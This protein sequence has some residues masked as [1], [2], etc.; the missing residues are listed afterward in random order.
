M[1]SYVA[2]LKIIINKFSDCGEKQF[3]MASLPMPRCYHTSAPVANRVI[4]CNGESQDYSV[5]NRLRLASTVEEFYPHSEQW[6]ARQCTGEAP[7][8]GVRRSASASS[9]GFLFTYGGRD[10]DDKFLGS[11]HQLSAKTYE[12]NELSPQNAQGDVPM[13]KWGAAMVACDDVLAL[14]GGYG[15]PHGPT[16]R[17]SSF[18]KNTGRSDGRGWTNEFHIY[19][20]KEG[21]DTCTIVTK[22]WLGFLSFVHVQVH[23]CTL[24][25]LNYSTI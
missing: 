2:L 3:D 23:T 7:A 4:V 5:Q 22:I 15:I 24:Y 18:I 8:P 12:W 6:D 11:L 1:T 9:K 14:L 25:S 21:T 17:G 19:R 20:L 16:Q 13:P 10:S